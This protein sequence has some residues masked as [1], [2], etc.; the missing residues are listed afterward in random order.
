MSEI[1]TEFDFVFKRILY[2]QPL[3]FHSKAFYVLETVCWLE[4]KTFF[5]ESSPV[6]D[7]FN[8]ADVRFFIIDENKRLYKLFHI[9]C[10]GS[11]GWEYIVGYF[12]ENHSVDNGKYN[13]SEIVDV[14]GR[15]YGLC[16]NLFR[17]AEIRSHTRR[18]LSDFGVYRVEGMQS[19]VQT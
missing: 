2:Q 12:A 3:I 18:D 19:V 17:R 16:Q 15:S 10:I 5:Q 13:K 6:R 11:A 14:R 7:A 9:F 1:G 4:S 8:V